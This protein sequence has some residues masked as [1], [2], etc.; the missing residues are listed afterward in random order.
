MPKITFNNSNNIFFQSVKTSVDN[1]FTSKNL[2]K[3]G[4]WKLYLKTWIMIPAALGLYIYLLAGHYSAVVGIMA[5]FLLGLTLVCIAFN[6]MHDACH[7]SYSGKKWVNGIMEFTMNGLGSNAFIWKIKHNI[8]HHTYTN[9]D[10]LDD[11]IANGPLLRQ[12]TTQK[13]MPMHRF[14]FLYMF[15]LYSVSTLSWMLHADFMWYFRRKINNTPIRRIDPWQ[16]LVFWVSKLLYVFFYIAVPIYF[17][18]WQPWL[19]GF[20]IIHF[21][22]GL[23]LSVVFQ[24]AHMVE[25]TTFDI[26]QESPKV[27]ESE[28][29][30]HEIKTTADFAPNNR[31]V[32]WFVGGLNFQIEHHLFP[33]ISHVH[34]FALSKI[35]RRQCELLGL[36]YNY[37]PSAWQAVCSHIRLMKRMGNKQPAVAL[38]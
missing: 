7:G 2:E 33:Q 37:Y 22:M 32:S 3:T 19:T 15:V 13:W 20:L 17:L 6:V 25:K 23:I 28:W 9:I 26:A 8:I 18:G 5:A 34:Y 24:L 38:S 29:A 27:I 36:P 10:G 12:C 4:N 21:T 11:D 16:H 30:V 14:Q 31:I 35:V 1:Y